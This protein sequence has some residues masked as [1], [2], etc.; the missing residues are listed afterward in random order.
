MIDVGQIIAFENGEQTEADSVRMFADLIRSGTVWSLQGTYGRTAASLIEA[1]VIDT[2]GNIL[3]D[4]E[5][6]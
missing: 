2:G 3:I 5:E 1:G 4:L 6:D